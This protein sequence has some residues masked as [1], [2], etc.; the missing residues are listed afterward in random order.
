MQIFFKYLPAISILEKVGLSFF[1]LIYFYFL[2]VNFI[3]II[4]TT[5]LEKFCECVINFLTRM[6]NQLNLV[7]LTN[8]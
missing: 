7:L 5:N 6:L 4:H 3:I 1:D 2:A 8:N